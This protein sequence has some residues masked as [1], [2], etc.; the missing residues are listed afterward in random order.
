MS[1][2]VELFGIPRLRAG[3]AATTVDGAR[4]GDILVELARRFPQLAHTCI[5]HDQLQS[6]YLASINGARFIT[7]PA[8]AIGPDDA[9]L[10]LS[11]DA[12][13]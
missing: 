11:A 5:D 9:L 2:R 10:I 12:G 13:G 6:G 7:D 1:I 8:T 4:L 3:V